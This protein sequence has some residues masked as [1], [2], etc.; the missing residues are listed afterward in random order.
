MRPEHA[1]RPGATDER[2]VRAVGEFSPEQRRAVA[3]AAVRQVVDTLERSGSASADA[4]RPGP[5]RGGQPH[6]QITS[7]GT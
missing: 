7:K 2:R 6:D 1:R 4:D 5:N 3:Q